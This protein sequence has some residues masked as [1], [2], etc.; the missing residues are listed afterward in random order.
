MKSNLLEGID[1]AV[2]TQIADRYGFQD[3]HVVEQ[4]FVDFAAY[5][6]VS[7]L[8]PCTIFGGMCMYLHARGMAQ[9]LSHDVDI[10]TAVTADDVDKAVHDAFDPMQGCQARLTVP[11]H[12]HPIKSLR[13]YRI[14]YESRLGGEGDVKMDCLCSFRG[15][16]PTEVVH[17]PPVLGIGRPFKARVL[18]REALLVDKMTAL[19]LGEIGLP[20]WRLRDAPKQVYDIAT[21]IRMANERGLAAALGMLDD[22]IASRIGLHE[23]SRNITA[24]STIASIQRSVESFLNFKSAAVMSKRYKQNL[25]NFRTKHLQNGGERYQKNERVDDLFAVMLFSACAGNVIGG[26]MSASEAAKEVARCVTKARG[27]S[28]EEDQDAVN[29]VRRR[30][31]GTSP[32]KDVTKDFL[33]GLSPGQLTVLETTYMFKSHQ[34]S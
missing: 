18:T 1:G 5:E 20:E 3:P 16:L 17:V 2:I 4:L 23:D 25:E 7:E 10:M 12:P 31:R 29:S 26:T 11:Q 22:A 15:S 13:S 34:A 14:S 33:W 32:H 28:E 19:A 6:H 8:L 21:L 27:M 24:L 9:R 30:L